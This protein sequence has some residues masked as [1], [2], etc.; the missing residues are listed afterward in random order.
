MI[1]LF[2]IEHFLFLK[3]YNEYHKNKEL[4]HLVLLVKIQLLIQQVYKSNIP[5]FEN[6]IYFFLYFLSNLF[7]SYHHNEHL[8]SL[9]FCPN[10]IFLHRLDKLHRIWS[11]RH[12]IFYRFTFKFVSTM[13]HLT[14]T[15]QNILRLNNHKNKPP[16]HLMILLYIYLMMDK[17]SL[18]YFKSY[19]VHYHNEQSHHNTNSYYHPSFRITLFLYLLNNIMAFP[20]NPFQIIALMHCSL[21]VYIPSNI[22]YNHTNN[23]YT[24]RNILLIHP[25]FFHHTNLYD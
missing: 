25:D 1:Q 16:T 23:H 8:I 17:N 7:I 13:D 20:G 11:K 19:V 24:N 5:I 15:Y 6:P 21:K 9:Y 12:D 3:Q 14:N 4:I 22:F 2:L 10:H 18:L